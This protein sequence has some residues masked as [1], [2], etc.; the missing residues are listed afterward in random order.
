MFSVNK[1]GQITDADYKEEHDFLPKWEQLK[2]DSTKKL[3]AKVKVLAP[4]VFQ[5]MQEGVKVDLLESL[6]L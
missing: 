4:S 5:K 6:D 2:N 1:V 3:K